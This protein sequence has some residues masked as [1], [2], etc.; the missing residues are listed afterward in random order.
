MRNYSGL[1][2]FTTKQE[3]KSLARRLAE[4]LTTDSKSIEIIEVALLFMIDDDGVLRRVTGFRFHGAC[5]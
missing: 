1:L 2:S 4:S 3:S 5:S